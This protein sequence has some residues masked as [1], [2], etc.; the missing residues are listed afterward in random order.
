MR[1]HRAGRA[2]P[3]Q[4]PAGSSAKQT[5]ALPC[6]LGS[7]LLA[8]VLQ[9]VMTHSTA[10]RTQPLP[11]PAAR[12]LPHCSAFSRA[13]GQH[14]LPQP[15]RAAALLWDRGR[16]LPPRARRGDGVTAIFKA[17][18]AAFLSPLARKL[19]PCPGFVPS[20]ISC[21]R[22]GL[23]TD[24]PR[25]KA[26]QRERF[27][28]AFGSEQPPQ[29]ASERRAAPIASV[30][31]G[32]GRQPGQAGTRRVLQAS[33]MPPSS[34]APHSSARCR[35]GAARSP[36]VPLSALSSEPFPCRVGSRHSSDQRPEWALRGGSGP[37]LRPLTP[38]WETAQ[39][40][41]FPPLPPPL[42]ISEPLYT[43][44]TRPLPTPLRPPGA[45]ALSPAPPRPAL[46]PTPP[47]T[48]RTRTRSRSPS[49]PP[50]PGGAARARGGARDGGGA[51]GALR[52]EPPARRGPVSAGP[53]RGEGAPGRAERSGLRTTASGPRPFPQRAAARLRAELGLP[54]RQLSVP[55]GSRSRIPHRPNAVGSG[56]AERC[57]IGAEGSAVPSCRAA[58]R[59]PPP[60]RL[61]GCAAPA[62]RSRPRAAAPWLRCRPP[63]GS[64]LRGSRV[65]LSG[66]G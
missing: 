5:G 53:G 56:G 28:K 40:P 6:R 27:A 32:E 11:G 9:R 52:P 3:A 15:S 18:F 26:L 39:P 64:A 46:S 43:P 21:R 16:V 12:A 57:G 17:D 31:S 44:P 50:S 8:P 10:L 54:G 34:E 47:R 38:T 13:A 55:G 60:T 23:L 45:A 24:L 33:A 62:V 51:G 4:S 1:P 35:S 30:L 37:A 61:R 42:L 65:S 59:A 36:S 58:H 63:V 19:H 29:D 7:G 25:L 48:A 2:L 14:L 22:A 66:R 49:R 41:P 20:S